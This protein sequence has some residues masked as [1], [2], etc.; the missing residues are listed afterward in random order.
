M[1]PPL[2]S[3]RLPR[4]PLQ[5][6][7]LPTARACGVLQTFLGRTVHRKSSC[8]RGA[9][10]EEPTAVLNTTFRRVVCYPGNVL[11]RLKE[12]C[13]CRASSERPIAPWGMVNS[14]SRSDD[15]GLCHCLLFVQR[16]GGAHQPQSSQ[17]DPPLRCAHRQWGSGA[18]RAI[19]MMGQPTPWMGRRSARPGNPPGVSEPRL[20]SHTH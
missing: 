1:C 17:P 5:L 4:S 12:S 18:W 20:R 8:R 15:T 2:P 14:D 11:V 19:R 6:P 9:G 10:V 7:L 13:A 3:Q 16:V